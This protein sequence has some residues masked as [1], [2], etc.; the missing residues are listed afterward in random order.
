MAL[1]DELENYVA[2]TFKD[3]WTVTDA[4]VIP[5]PEDITLDNSASHFD[6]A[7]MLYADLDGSTNMVTSENWQFASEIYKNYL[8]CC[9]RLIRNEGGEITAYDGDRVMGVFIGGSQSSNATRCALKINYA[10]KNIIN[11][12]IKK[13]YSSST[14][15][16]NQCVGIDVSEVR[17]ARTGVRGDNDL[18][19]VGRAANYAAKLTDLANEAPTW[20]T[21]AVYD[22]LS[23]DAKFAGAEKRNMWDERSWTSMGGIAIYRSTWWWAI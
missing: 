17:V 2:K 13:Q 11:P 10:V 16:V 22:R 1:K 20:I 3:Q 21:K 23:D 19:W 6:L 4:K 9:S 7:T 14:F 15:Q 5:D 8:Y 12:A 18:V